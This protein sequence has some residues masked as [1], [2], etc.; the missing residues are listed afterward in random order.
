[1][2][3]FRKVEDKTFAFVLFYILK[4]IPYEGEFYEEEEKK[5][6]TKVKKLMACGEKDLDLRSEQDLLLKY[7]FLQVYTEEEMFGLFCP[8]NQPLYLY[9]NPTDENEPVVINDIN[10]VGNCTYISNK[11]V[12]STVKFTEEMSTNNFFVYFKEFV[13]KNHT[14]VANFAF[15]F[16]DGTF[17]LKYKEQMI[18]EATNI[19][20]SVAY[21]FVL[22]TLQHL[23]P[24]WIETQK[25]EGK[26]VN[27][28]NENFKI[29]R[30][31][32]I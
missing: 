13:Q 31:E 19:N 15:T 9:T 25:A 12:C 24:L 18:F 29:E 30:I 27:G 5:F 22:Y 14:E 4:Q 11:E 2:R 3:Y 10:V 17:T 32:R 20:V 26:T 7:K 1:M 6:G 21:S 28:Y 8:T 16:A 23:E